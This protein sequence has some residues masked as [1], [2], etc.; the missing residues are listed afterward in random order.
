MTGEVG[1]RSVVDFRQEQPGIA[2]DGACSRVSRYERAESGVGFEDSLLPVG[3]ERG[4]ELD[5]R[6]AD[7]V[8]ASRIDVVVIDAASIE[9]RIK[10]PPRQSQALIGVRRV[11]RENG[12]A[13]C[14][15]TRT[16]R[17]AGGGRGR[18][19]L[20]LGSIRSHSQ[21]PQREQCG[22]DRSG[23]HSGGPLE[24]AFPRQ[25][26]DDISTLASRPGRGNNRRQVMRQCV[27]FATPRKT[28]NFQ[29]VLEDLRPPP[30]LAAPF[31]S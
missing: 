28:P 14:V 26:P 21:Q 6:N 25:W 20:R 22:S 24:T 1:W 27:F 11:C 12:E 2:I 31:A 5:A 17:S 10:H 23:L 30:E 4:R 15:T 29:E 8:R 18:G 19:I 7:A 3:F 13:R 16:A 9:G